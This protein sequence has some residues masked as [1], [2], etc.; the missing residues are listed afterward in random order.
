MLGGDDY[1]D[2]A[3]S[4]VNFVT[5]DTVQTILSGADKTHNEI[6]TFQND[7]N[8]TGPLLVNGGSVEIQ[9]G[10]TCI[11]KGNDTIMTI[12]ATDT[13]ASGTT[14]S[15]TIDADQDLT[16]TRTSTSALSG[17]LALVSNGNLDI[18]TLDPL[19]LN[20]GSI[21]IQSVKGIDL[22]ATGTIS[23]DANNVTSNA[24]NLVDI[25]VAYTTKSRY[26]STLTTNTNPT[27]TNVATTAFKV[28]N[29]VG[30]DKLNI[31]PT[32]TTNTNAT[33]TEVATTAFKVQ[34]VVGTDK[35]IIAPGVSTS[36]NA[37][38]SEV[39]DTAYRVQD[40]I[41]IGNSLEITPVLTTNKNA[42]I[43]EV[44][45]TA[46]KVQTTPGTDKLNINPA[47]TTIINGEVSVTSQTSSLYLE[48]SDAVVLTGT[49]NG[50]IIYGGATIKGNYGLSLTTLTN[51][52]IT[53]VA[54]TAFKVQNVAGT[55]K[56]NIT[57]TLTTLTNTNVDVVAPLHATRYNV[58]TTASN[59]PLLS[60]ELSGGRL[61]SN[62]AVGTTNYFFNFGNRSTTLLSTSNRLPSIN[63][64]PKF[65]VVVLDG[66]GFTGG[67]TVTLVVSVYNATSALTAYTATAAVITTASVVTASLP[68]TFN[69]ALTTGCIVGIM[70]T[71][72][73]TIAIT[74][75]TKNIYATIYSQ[76]V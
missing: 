11:F 44:A 13:L 71:V 1:S 66:G 49:L 17:T 14:G 26:Q 45:T 20:I 35:L 74:L 10:G 4:L 59:V 76:Q 40:S 38:I 12:A 22:I 50:V 68:M 36:T 61:L 5:T 47:D 67:G 32:L 8:V 69:T 73:C 6:N 7:V 37:I 23:S 41:G 51:P 25:Q 52:T 58:G 72:T 31:A 54:T 34:N 43:T 57:P 63:I 3:A 56:L 46:Y 33:I 53:N 2:V 19:A 39:F 15:I 16:I 64:V 48:A 21:T 18:L 24:A 55:D 70:V 9:S 62:Q 42:T 27:I 28:Q 65:C 30:T 75:S 60:H 29:V